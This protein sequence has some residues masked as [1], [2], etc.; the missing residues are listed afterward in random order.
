EAEWEYAA[1][2]GTSSPF[3]WRRT[4]RSGNANCEGCAGNPPPQT[5]PTGFLRRHGF[6]LFAVAG[7]AAEWVEHCWNDAYRGAPMD[8]S[9]WTT[10][11]CRQR[12]ARGG[13]FAREANMV[14]V[15]GQCRS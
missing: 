1:R 2:A 9:A 7:N 14:R 13:S 8:G 11:Q 5:L 15:A 10:G 6:V 3:W 12:V 4:S